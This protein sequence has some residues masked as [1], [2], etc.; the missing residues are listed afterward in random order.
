MIRIYLIGYMGVGKTTVGK[1]LAQLFD[2]GFVDLDKFIENRYHKTVPEIFAERGEE[3]F[4]LIEQ[5]ALIEVS[6]IEDVVISTG[7][8]TPCFFDNVGL[9][10]ETGITVYIHAEPDELAVRLRA[11]KNIRPVVAGKSGEELT[12]FIASHLKDREK[13]YNQAQIVYKTDRL[14]TK[15]EIHLTVE[16]IAHEIKKLLK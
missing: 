10:N 16:G 11:S 8:G 13:F 1:K 6:S 14:I 15:D 12:A 4:R 9:M 7:G 5:K 3:E 2:I